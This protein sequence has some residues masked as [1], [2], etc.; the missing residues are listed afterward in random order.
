MEKKSYKAKYIDCELLTFFDILEIARYGIFPTLE[1]L[2]EDLYRG[3]NHFDDFLEYKEMIA[4]IR[5]DIQTG[6]YDEIF[7]SELNQN[8]S[9]LKLIITLF[10]KEAYDTH[11]FHEYIN[12]ID[13]D[14]SKALYFEL[15]DKLKDEILLL[16]NYIS[17]FIPEFIYQSQLNLE[18]IS[19]LKEKI[20]EDYEPALIDFFQKIEAP[21]KDTFLQE[22][23]STFN[24]EFGRSIKALIE[25]LE[26][27]N[28]LIIPNRQN[29]KFIELLGKHF[30][31]KI[32]SYQSIND[33]K[34]ITQFDLDPIELKLN[35]IL[36]KIK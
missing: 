12:L 18:Q 10:E 6:E 26:K 25:V 11:G 36:D 9:I 16:I 29:R 32:G 22:L 14:E 31:R 4:S 33:V 27:N 35:I 24:I 13:D 30:E 3:D 28:L 21:Q 19:E 7:F 15:K 8:Q 5:L 20:K 23:K 17:D 2:K 1:Q 34:D